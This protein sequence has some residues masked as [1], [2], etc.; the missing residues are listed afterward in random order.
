MWSALCLAFGIWHLLLLS[1]FTFT[2][3]CIIIIIVA[4]L[5]KIQLRIGFWYSSYNNQYMRNMWFS[6]IFGWSVGRLVL[7]YCYKKEEQ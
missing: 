3:I 1:T 7:F 2:F 5:F 4:F 6:I